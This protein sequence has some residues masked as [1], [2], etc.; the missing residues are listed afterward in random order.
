MDKVKIP[1]GLI[2]CTY[3]FNKL[4]KKLY[5]ENEKLFEYSK[6]N[7][8]L[9]IIQNESMYPYQWNNPTRSGL[10]VK[11]K[12]IESKEEY[13]LRLEEL[14]LY[15]DKVNEKLNTSFTFEKET[16]ETNK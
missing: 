6:I 15:M 1:L 13:K 11:C 9:D 10:R 14:K 16:Q 4:T 5:E 3:T 12:N 2:S 8:W 7:G